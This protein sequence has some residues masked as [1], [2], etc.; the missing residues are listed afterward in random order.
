MSEAEDKLKAKRDRINARLRQLKGRQQ[1]EGRK[2]E[3]RKKILAG[4]FL[5]EQAKRDPEVNAWMLKGL[6][7]FLTRP[8]ERAL[9][10]LPEAVSE[11]ATSAD[12]QEAGSVREPAPVERES[13]HA[14]H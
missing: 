7:W 6:A 12:P 10:G 4:A 1:R 8:E 9:F 11:K 14:T 5:I 2:A 3:T 13:A